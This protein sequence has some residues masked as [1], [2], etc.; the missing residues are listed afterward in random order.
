VLVLDGGEVKEYDHPYILLRKQ[1]SIFKSMVE[2]SG[3][4]TILI[5]LAKTAWRKTRLVDVD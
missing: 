3:E 4:E 1:D 5:D 2:Q